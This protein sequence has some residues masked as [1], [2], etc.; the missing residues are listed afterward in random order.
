MEA[1]HIYNSKTVEMTLQLMKL[2]N[3]GN[4]GDNLSKLKLV[5]N[6]GLTRS[7]KAHHKDTHLFLGKQPAEKLGER[8]PHF[9]V[10]WIQNLASWERFNRQDFIGKKSHR[11]SLFF[12]PK[13]RIEMKERKERKVR[14][15]DNMRESTQSVIIATR[16]G[17]GKWK[18][19]ITCIN[20]RIECVRKKNPVR[21]REINEPKN[22]MV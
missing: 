20:K 14:R 11:V 4:G 19:H 1:S 9:R 7:I 16:T 2:T 15:R 10:F 18:A 12:L 22:V 21:Q 8:Q 6:G 17:N 13:E 3:G 5:Q